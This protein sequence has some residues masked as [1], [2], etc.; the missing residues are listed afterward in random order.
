MPKQ[1]IRPDGNP[2]EINQDAESAIAKLAYQLWLQRGSPDGSPEEDW[3]RAESL[4]RSEA[5]VRGSDPV[6]VS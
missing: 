3:H 4:L 6:P 1:S 2:R 5:S